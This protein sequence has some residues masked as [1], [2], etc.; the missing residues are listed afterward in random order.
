MTQE[1]EELKFLKKELLLGFENICLKGTIDPKNYIKKKLA[2]K[3]YKNCRKCGG[4]GEN[5]DNKF[6]YSHSPLSARVSFFREII[7]TDE[8]QRS[9]SVFEIRHK[10]LK[11]IPR[12]DHGQEKLPTSGIFRARSVRRLRSVDQ[13]YRTGEIPRRI[14]IS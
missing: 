5:K 4:D 3:L 8:Y 9:P 2:A 7:K 13:N 11:G 14:K 1:L 6:V 12:S 10:T